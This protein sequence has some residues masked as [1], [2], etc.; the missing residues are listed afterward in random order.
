MSWSTM[1]DVPN[2][3]IVD[4]A[5]TA[6]SGY[7]LKAY[8]PG[9]TTSTSIAIAAAGTSPQTSI[10]AN[11]EGKW[12]V[13]GNEILPYIDRTHKWGVFANAT[14]AAANTPFYMGPFDN[15]GRA[16]ASSDALKNYDT[17]LLAV[18]DAAAINEGDDI[19]LV[20]RVA[21]GGGGAWWKAIASTTNNTYNIV[22]TP[23][24]TAISLKL[25][26]KEV[27]IAAEYGFIEGDVDNSAPLVIIIA[28]NAA[29]DFGN[30]TFKI[31]TKADI[32]LTRDTTLKSTA[33]GGLVT[34]VADASRGDN[35][36]IN[37]DTF[38]LETKDLNVSGGGVSGYPFYVFDNQESTGKVTINGGSFNDSYVGSGN[39]GNAGCYIRGGFEEVNVIGAEF[40][41]HTRL[42]GNG[43]P[44]VTG[45]SGL[46]IT[47]LN[48]FDVKKVQV[49]KSSFIEI[50]NG[51]TSDN[52]N[53]TDADGLKIF[54][55]IAADS[56]RRTVASIDD[57]YF[58]NCKGR[59]IK[60]QN[61]VT[62]V[63]NPI[64]YRNISGITGASVEIDLQIHGGDIISPTFMYEDSDSGEDTFVRPVAPIS[65]FA[66]GTLVKPRI[67][68]ISDVT[69][70]DNTATWSGTHDGSGNAAVLTDSTQSWTTNE[71]VGKRINN[72]TDGSST[73]ITANTAT[74]V[75]GVLSG[76]TD[77]DWD[78]SDSYIIG[79]MSA[80]V[81]ASQSDLS[82]VFDSVVN[83]NNVISTASHSSFMACPALTST[84]KFFASI[85]NVYIKEISIANGLFGFASSAA[86]QDKAIIKVDKFTHSGTSTK[87]TYQTT[88]PASLAK[89]SLH[90]DAAF[91]VSATSESGV[92]SP[93]SR[94]TGVDEAGVRTSNTGLHTYSIS[95]VD[96]E[97]IS[98]EIPNVDNRG[99]A[100]INTSLSRLSAGVVS[101][102]SSG[103]LNFGAAAATNFNPGGTSNNDADGDLN[104][105]ATGG[106]LFV[107]NR[108]G[109][110]RTITINLQG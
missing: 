12:E 20:E 86:L 22:D 74:T 31:K 26:D 42:L 90:M 34:A 71:L 83:I 28:N 89:P 1:A 88:A 84:G 15:V 38:S 75:T 13:S 78:V 49:T 81:T 102:D 108:L 67:S 47:Q 76:G 2:P 100:H 25:H 53:N 91:G 40:K 63:T 4:A 64:I 73:I 5:G 99:I 17:L 39:N 110:T 98:I 45:T 93:D 58:K 10:T 87:P 50:T 54:S 94:V 92:S 52:A 85:D 79:A 51:E 69:I 70:H 43:N 72:F 77:D 24:N 103:A 62:T 19:Y 16:S 48:T 55:N 18:A 60:T 96:D 57:C 33:G 68:N 37:C 8:L 6:G 105:W 29:V 23:L 35:I 56:V 80:I 21:G 66:T 14:D 59:A 107:K 61:D 3:I 95:M 7:V 36:S 46:T 44:G 11:A 30:K 41:N 109:S 27:A 82:S 65:M 104:V 9:T 101:L 32:T 106:S 97:E